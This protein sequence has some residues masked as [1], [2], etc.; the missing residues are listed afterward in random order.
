MNDIFNYQE[1]NFESI[2]H[3]DEFN[4]EYWYARELM[5]LLEYSKWENFHKVIKRAM[6]ACETSNNDVNYCFPEVR[7]SIISGKRRIIKNN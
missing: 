3:V 2:K 5:P 6:I 4:Y 7:K 1:K